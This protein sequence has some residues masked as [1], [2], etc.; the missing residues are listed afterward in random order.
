MYNICCDFPHDCIDKNKYLLFNINVC[1]FC[2]KLY[3]TVFIT[4]SYGTYVICYVIVN[5]VL[6]V[7]CA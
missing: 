3:C 2:T 5:Y 1:I 7:Y 4:L 6:T